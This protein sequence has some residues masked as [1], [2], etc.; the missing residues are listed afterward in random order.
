MAKHLE[1]SRSDDFT[2]LLDNI[3]CSQQSSPRSAVTRGAVAARRRHRRLEVAVLAGLVLGGCSPALTRPP[4][5]QPDLLTLRTTSDEQAVAAGRRMLGRLL[6]RTKAEYDRY[7]AGER[8]AP[9]VIDILIISG[10]GTGGPSGRDSSR[11]GS[12]SPPST[13]S[14]SPSSPR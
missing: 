12:R 1:P 3:P 13:R 8:Q 10:G 14:P 11:G 6:A 5:T 2:S 9:P 4:V 7:T